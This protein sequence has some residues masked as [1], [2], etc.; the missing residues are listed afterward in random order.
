MGS[1]CSPLVVSEGGREHV[2]ARAVLQKVCAWSLITG[3][4]AVASVDPAPRT[5]MDTNSHAGATSPMET[6]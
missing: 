2:R 4:F 5:H 1:Q 6:F 3:A